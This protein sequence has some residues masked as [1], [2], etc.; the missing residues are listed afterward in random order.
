[1]VCQMFA[2]SYKVLQPL[3]SLQAALDD[4]LNDINEERCRGEPDADD[5]DDDS[6]DAS[7]D[8]EPAHDDERTLILGEQLSQGSVSDLVDSEDEKPCPP[9]TSDEEASDSD[10]SADGVPNI[11]ADSKGNVNKHLNLSD[12]NIPPPPEDPASGDEAYVTPPK[13]AAAAAVA[14]TGSSVKAKFRKLSLKD[15]RLI[16]LKF[17]IRFQC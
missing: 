1:M 9:F 6:S 12:L 17:S 7:Q 15:T 4:I 16:W 13:R 2:C 10:S 5:D 8:E 14:D 3:A 11:P